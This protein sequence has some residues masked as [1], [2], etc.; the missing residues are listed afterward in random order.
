M[1]LGIAIPIAVACGLL[2]GLS[3]VVYPKWATAIW[4]ALA[5]FSIHAA[6]IGSDRRYDEYLALE[7]RVWQLE[8]AAGKPAPEPVR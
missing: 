4:I 3:V 1:N 2:A 7:D 8:K 5:V 6:W